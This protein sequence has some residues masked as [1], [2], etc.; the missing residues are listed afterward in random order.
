MLALDIYHT[1]QC[2]S[3]ELPLPIEVLAGELRAFHV[4]KPM[5][6]ITQVDFTL[7]PT[8]ELGK[9]F[10]R[11]VQID[12]SLQAI[13]T[14]SREFDVLAGESRQALVDLIKDNRLRDLDHMADYLRYGPDS[15]YGLI[16]MPTPVMRPRS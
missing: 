10:M 11:M 8:N 16:C 3:L 12:D 4:E 13:A 9:H 1:N 6:D 7:T 14:A 15:L 5:N 2:L